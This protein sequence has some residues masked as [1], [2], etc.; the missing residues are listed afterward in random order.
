VL[1]NISFSV[2]Y[3]DFTVVMGKS[4]SGKSTLL[5]S[6]S[7]L[8]SIDR[9]EIS[10]DGIR[11]D[12]KKEKELAKIRLAD[13]GFVFQNNNL[14][15]I[16]TLF[17]NVALP[18]IELKRFARENVTEILVSLGLERCLNKLPNFCSGGEKQ[19][20]A[21]ARA[22]VNSSL[23]F[24]LI[25]FKEFAYFFAMM[26]I[27]AAL[28][29]LDKI[30][31]FVSKTMGVY[32]IANANGLAMVLFITGIIVII[33]VVMMV[34]FGLAIQKRKIADLVRFEE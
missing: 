28:P 20:C 27:G 30:A 2:H 24:A 31:Q 32:D 4:G 17:E 18:A 10:L 1:D 23:L 34:F 7:L 14:I 12:T 26:M 3:Q 5:F 9:G 16:M 25:I 15:E 33:D 6:V 13:F 29:L 22:L 21:I 11:L 19:R 8:D